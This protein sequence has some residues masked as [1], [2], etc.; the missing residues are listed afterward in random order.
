MCGYDGH[1]FICDFEDLA[2]CGW[3]SSNASMYRWERR[4][5]GRSLPDSGP[6][7]DFTT[8]TSTGWFVAVT[9]VDSQTSSRALLESPTMRQSA[10]TCRILLRYFIWDA[11]YKGLDDMVLW[12]SVE[13]DGGLPAVAWRPEGGSVR[14]WREATVFLGRV[15]GPFRLQLHSQRSQGLPGDVAIDQLEFLDCALPGE[16]GRE[17]MEAGR[18]S[19]ASAGCEVATLWLRARCMESLSRNSENERRHSCQ[20]VRAR[21][22]HGAFSAAVPEKTCGEGS[23]KCGRQGCV[24]ARQICDGTDDC[25]DGTDEAKC[26][27]YWACDFENDLCGWDLRTI[28]QLKF[29]RSSQQNI[30]VSGNPIDGPGRD[31]TANKASGHFLYLTKPS[32]GELKN[33]WSSFQSPVLEP[34]NSTHPCR[35]TM[36]THQFGPRSGGLSVL[37]VYAGGMPAVWERGGELG[38]LWVKAEV[39]FVVHS[40]FQILFVGA[41]RD[42]EFGGIAIDDIV[43]SPGCR[44]SNAF[45]TSVSAESSPSVDFP[46]PPKHPCTE[47]SK[48]CDFQV[49]CDSG[50]DENQ[51]GDFSF[52]NGNKGWTD[53][54]LGT[55]GWALPSPVA[56]SPFTEEYLYV[57]EA[58]GQ[59][60]TEA[61]TRS[62]LLGPSGPACTLR[63]T[64]SLTG[65]TP[66]IGEVSV[67][68][69]DKVL[70]TQSR[71]WE[72]T[73]K[74]EGTPSEWVKEVYIG[75]R[76][77]R[78][79]L[80]FG[81]F[82]RQ[83][84]SDSKI[85]VKNVRYLGC[86]PKYIPAIISGLSCNFEDG[87]CGWYQDQVDNFDWLYLLG[88]D[89]TIGTGNCLT[90]D[91]WIHSLRG[92][93]GR[94]LSLPQLPTAKEFCMSFYYKL[95][96]P[97]T[98]AL[99]VKVLHSDGSESLLWTAS[100]A[101]SNNW[102]RG[103][104]S[105]PQQLISFQLIFE[106]LRTGFD[107]R[108]A[109]DDVMILDHPCTA[110][111]ICSF[112]GTHC[113]YT[114]SGPARWV[115]QN[116]AYGGVQPGP[117]FD[118]TL[119]TNKGYYMITD[120]GVHVL[121]SGH[122]TSLTS[123]F[124]NAA[125]FGEC[126]QFWY[127]MRGDSP[128]TLNVYMK[129]RQGERVRVFSQS[130]RQGGAWR[131]GYGT[132]NS[133]RD[134]Q[135]EIEV[136][137]AGGEEAHVA[138]DDITF[139]PHSCPRQDAECN[140]EEDL[141]SWF[142]TQNSSLD[143]LD[144]QLSSA[145]GNSYIAPPFDHTL[146]TNKGHFLFLPSSLRN[147]SG[148]NAWLLSPPL[149]PTKGT[150]LR[151]WV[152]R[153]TSRKISSSQLISFWTF[154]TPK[155]E[156][157]CLLLPKQLYSQRGVG[158]TD[159]AKLNV[160]KLSEGESTNL[161]SLGE[162][163]GVWRRFD[164]N[165]TSQNEYQVYVLLF[166]SLPHVCGHIGED[167]NSCGMNSA[168]KKSY[169]V[170]E[171][172]KGTDGVVALDDIK[173]TLGI[174]CVGQN[175]D[176]PEESKFS[177]SG[178]GEGPVDRRLES[179]RGS[180]GV[181][182]GRSEGSV[183]RRSEL[184]RRSVDVVGERSEGSKTGR[185]ETGNKGSHHHPI[186]MA[187]IAVSIVVLIL[188]LVVLVGLLVWF[189][190]RMGQPEST[191]PRAQEQPDGFS[192]VAY[193]TE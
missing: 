11:G 113:G 86:H 170:F 1:T 144:W 178:T 27:Q 54:S 3:K 44:K 80:E 119:E 181:V 190:R 131:Y 146:G 150:C 94:L 67:S 2:T 5:R 62:P 154:P 29:Q 41:I 106:A 15:S 145:M 103:L 45:F 99:S 126:V 70:H 168:I 142:N 38:D 90:V 149:P 114:S 57:T 78:F 117:Q 184:E 174:N 108:V 151:F 148:Q 185:M 139:T 109:I 182:G 116:S 34:T 110:P 133:T 112:E 65:S 179:E 43:M 180:M 186:N 39:E 75:A 160:I 79:Q 49:D 129:P 87:L 18:Q 121:P 66:D 77:H 32:N 156:N 74:T 138:I 155:Q 7:S 46:N 124:R 13:E 35:M 30:S 60:L 33:D 177:V 12:L 171:G 135:L 161:L 51:C 141:C 187:G 76:D 136:E 164:I 175:M 163:I 17:G 23:L 132:I 102:H 28:S 37:M 107:G 125:P 96:G 4:Q 153:P 97:Q 19:G 22:P 14:G 71:L 192:N 73:E 68:L 100:G 6:S 48:L 8:G 127:H 88:M 91:M 122:M 52:Q 173:Y 92:L 56:M 59:Q 104:C 101:H 159:D 143:L 98:G 169:I 152:Y 61:R 31:H 189:L 188:L 115:H 55:Q 36:Y 95:Y 16:A 9:S 118:H 111:D 10:P 191:Q 166:C 158:L 140:L 83:L 165:I 147:T 69:I 20:A 130:Q 172:I 26:E 120:S 82:I 81:G 105:V 64:Y 58:P 63:F 25:G 40:T 50:E 53:S 84:S 72:F 89:H 42:R 183:D 193:D 21:V 134:W 123:S 47:S 93:S 137:G 128:G 167:R 85:R 162:V 24:E 176:S 157:S